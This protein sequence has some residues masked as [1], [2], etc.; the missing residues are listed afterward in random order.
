VKEIETK[1]TVKHKKGPFN[2]KCRPYAIVRFQSK[3]SASAALSHFAKIPTQKD[4]LT[5]LPSSS[6]SL[7][8]VSFLDIDHQVDHQTQKDIDNND[9]ECA[10]IL[11]PKDFMSKGCQSKITVV[12]PTSNEMIQSHCIDQTIEPT[13]TPRLDPCDLITFHQRN[14]THIYRVMKVDRNTNIATLDRPYVQGKYSKRRRSN[15]AVIIVRIVFISSFLFYCLLC[16]YS[17]QTNPNSVTNC[18][19]L[20]LSIYNF[21]TTLLL[22]RFLIFEQTI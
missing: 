4:G 6:S 8:S 9:N 19:K 2:P 12:K 5:K 20:I 3:A 22:R 15:V 18:F 13:G 16:N 7:L 21:T 1:T 10:S 14:N 17:F 11:N